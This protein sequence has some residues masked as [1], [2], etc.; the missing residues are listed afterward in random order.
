MSAAPIPPHPRV[1][2]WLRP[3]TRRPGE[4]Q[5]GVLADGPV[6]SGIDT[7]EALLLRRLDGALP[8]DV[9]DHLALDAGIPHERWRTLLELLARLGVLTESAGPG[10]HDA[11][12]PAHTPRRATSPATSPGAPPTTS[13]LQIPGA[14]PAATRARPSGTDLGAGVLATPRE[15]PDGTGGLPRVVVDGCGPVASEIAAALARTGVRVVHGRAAVDRALASPDRPRP[16]LVVLV[17]SPVVDPRRADPWLRRGIVH[18]PV[19]PAAPRTVIGPVV[20]GSASAPCLWCLEHH[21]ADRD[22]AWPTVMSQSVA[23]IASATVASATH[24]WGGQGRTS[25]PAPRDVA[26]GPDGTDAAQTDE[27]ADPTDPADPA[28]VAVAVDVDGTHDAL[29]PGLAQLVVGSVTLLVSG[30]LQGRLPPPGVSVEV[31]PPWPRLDHRRWPV[32]PLCTGHL[33]VRPST[34]QPSTSGARGERP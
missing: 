22:E 21:R 33:I 18:L 8:L 15:G 28:S 10:T 4:V 26:T 6:V 9:V 32:H 7:V 2:V 24:P 23:T 12:D 3:L 34:A 17:G 11:D 30:A 25:T 5:F 31:S 27:A 29:A 14:N 16:D 13:P 19:T 1:P 20:D